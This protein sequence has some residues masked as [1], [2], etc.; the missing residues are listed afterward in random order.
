MVAGILRDH[1]DG[2]TVAAIADESG[3]RAAIVGKVLAAREAAGAAVRK[4]ADESVPSGV[5]LWVRGEAI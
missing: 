4:P 5:E 2:V 3:L 1:P